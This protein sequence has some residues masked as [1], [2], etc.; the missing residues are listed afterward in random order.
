[1]NIGDVVIANFQHGGV[2]SVDKTIGSC[3]PAAAE[4]VCDYLIPDSRWNPTE[5]YEEVQRR[6]L[7]RD[8]PMTSP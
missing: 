8:A 1:M 4:V 2:D 7:R 6:W 5:F 3:D